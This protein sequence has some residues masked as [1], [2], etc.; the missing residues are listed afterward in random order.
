M[1]DFAAARDCDQSLCADANLSHEAG[2]KHCGLILAV[3]SMIV[4]NLL[5]V[6]RKMKLLMLRLNLDRLSIYQSAS[7]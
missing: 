4:I 3:L 1:F 6:R 2:L 7:M 5:P